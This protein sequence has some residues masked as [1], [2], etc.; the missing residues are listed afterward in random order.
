MLIWL[1]SLDAPLGAAWHALT[2]VHPGLLLGGTV[3]AL[4]YAYLV[5]FLAIALGAV[6]A[7]LAKITPQLDANVSFGYST[8]NQITSNESNNTVGI[9]SQAFGGPGYRNNGLV[10]GLTDSLVGYR[11]GTPGLIWAEK[12]Q[13]KER[14]KDFR[15]S[16]IRN[17]GSKHSYKS[18]KKK[19]AAPSRR[20]N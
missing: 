7:G 3:V 15:S 9:G 2:G 17:V 18:S 20:R 1:G 19:Q 12:L 13:Q 8:V 6:E 11:A 4:L 10:S 5:R 16:L 14:D